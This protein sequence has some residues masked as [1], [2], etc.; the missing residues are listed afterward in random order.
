[1]VVPRL[2]IRPSRRRTVPGLSGSEIA[3][4]WL[5]SVFEVSPRP[6]RNAFGRLAEDVDDEADLVVPQ[7]SA[8]LFDHRCR[9]GARRCTT[10][11]LDTQRPAGRLRIGLGHALVEDEPEQ[12]HAR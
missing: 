7:T 9:L 2:W 10:I 3:R 5:P 11:E 4:I 6:S 1:M 12:L 8:S